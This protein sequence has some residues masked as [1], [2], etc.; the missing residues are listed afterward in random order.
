MPIPAPVDRVTVAGYASTG[1]WVDTDI[2]GQSICPNQALLWTDGQRTAL[3]P[4]SPSFATAL[5]RDGEDL[6]VLGRDEGADKFDRLV[7]WKN[8]APRV[9]DSDK[10]GYRVWA[11][12]ITARGG[13]VAVG[14]AQKRAP[15]ASRSSGEMSMSAATR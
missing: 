6:Y 9:L 5:A 1:V 3:S 8:G 15:P 10:E 14:G 2:P 11:G 13:K 7:V 4:G 12:A